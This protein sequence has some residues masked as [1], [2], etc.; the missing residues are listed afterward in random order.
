[1][2]NILTEHD[3]ALTRGHHEEQRRLEQV[4]ICIQGMLHG[5]GPDAHEE[6]PNT[7]PKS[8]G[9]ERSKHLHAMYHA[10]LKG[11]LDQLL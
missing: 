10:F 9:E 2:T 1:M 4:I 7:D 11:E 3:Q 6:A 8:A 5:I